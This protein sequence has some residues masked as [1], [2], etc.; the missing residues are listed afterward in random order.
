M[1]LHEDIPR[2]V[3]NFFTS[4]PSYLRGGGSNPPRPPG[5]LGY[6]GLLMVNPSRPPLPP[7]RPYCQPLNYPKYVK[8]YDQDFHV[9]VLKLPLEQIEK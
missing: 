1:S 2:E 9:K 3:N 4:Q 8:D 6:F 7:N 5:P